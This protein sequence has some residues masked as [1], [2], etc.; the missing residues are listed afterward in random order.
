M[1]AKWERPQSPSE[2]TELTR[3]YGNI[4][5]LHNLILKS[6]EI[7]IYFV[8]DVIFL[9]KQPSWSHQK[10]RIAHKQLWRTKLGAHIGTTVELRASWHLRIG[11]HTKIIE[12]PFGIP[13]N[14]RTDTILEAFRLTNAKS[15]RWERGITYM[16]NARYYS[17]SL[18]GTSSIGAIDFYHKISRPEHVLNN[19]PSLT[20]S[21][22]YVRHLINTCWCLKP[23]LLTSSFETDGFFKQLSDTGSPVDSPS[24]PVLNC[25][26]ATDSFPGS[27]R[28]TIWASRRALHT[29]FST[30]RPWRNEKNTLWQQP[31]HS[32]AQS[33]GSKRIR[34]V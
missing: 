18:I 1:Y 29:R 12:V 30:D 24:R 13:R 19:F 9:S 34:P 21:F 6:C 14:H 10:Y 11:K 31:S 2:P 8:V 33:G 4:F 26:S 15:G 28:V 20:P 16:D 27:D 32:G 25:R 23:G 22:F 3:G 7:N 17:L 5:V